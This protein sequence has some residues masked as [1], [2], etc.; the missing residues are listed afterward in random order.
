LTM[1][2]LAMLPLLAVFTG[3]ADGGGEHGAVGL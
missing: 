1:A 2:T 3:M